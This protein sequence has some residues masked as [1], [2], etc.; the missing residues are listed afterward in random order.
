MAKHRR[1]RKWEEAD[2]EPTSG[3]INLVDIW[4][5]FAVAL[6]LALV[7]SGV[8]RERSDAIEPTTTA[9]YDSDGKLEI[10]ETNGV[11]V[12]TMR[13]TEELRSGNGQRLGTA[14]RL[15]SGE[16]IYVP[17]PPKAKE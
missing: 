2:D 1:I 4:M 9:Q 8:I 6:L 16:V 14:Y 15:K 7:S 11:S 12:K 5:V 10:V 3:L 13:E 17:E